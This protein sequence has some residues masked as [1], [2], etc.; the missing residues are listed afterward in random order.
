MFTESNADGLGG[1][2][3]EH[4]IYGFEDVT[5]PP[6]PSGA[7]LTLHELNESGSPMDG[8]SLWEKLEKYVSDFDGV[9]ADDHSDDN[10]PYG[11]GVGGE[12]WPAAAAMC[13][14]LANHTCDLQGA[15]MLELGAGTGA[16]GLFAAGLGAGH[17]LLTDGGYGEATLR[18]LCAQNIAANAMLFAADSTVEIEELQWGREQTAS[19]L[20]VH[21]PFDW[22]VASDC[23]Y[24]H[25]AFGSDSRVIG[26]L[27]AAIGHLLR[28]HAPR[29]VP[30]R[31]VLAHEHRARDRGLPWLAEDSELAS[32]DAGDEQ[33]DSLW[34]AA[35]AEGLVLAPL[36]SERPRCV[37][38]AEF[39]SWTADLSIVEVRL[40]QE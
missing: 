32:W 13:S 9:E 37:Q 36:W 15:R 4:D 24:G 7:Q 21:E 16:V 33:L 39:R 28:E 12:V 26:S 27:C 3:D 6:L 19:L 35:R 31:V 23:S 8:D 30:P 14:F 25:D 10:D 18:D 34:A 22:V 11:A 1:G 40:A 38:R 2:F 5:L 17:V 29:G 20:D